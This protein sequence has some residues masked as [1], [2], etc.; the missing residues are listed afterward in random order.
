MKIKTQISHAAINQKIDPNK[1]EFAGNTVDTPTTS[2]AG[3]VPIKTGNSRPAWA[4]KAT[5]HDDLALGTA[6]KKNHA[7][8]IEP[9]QGHLD[10]FLRSAYRHLA[11]RWTNDRSAA[12]DQVGSA[13]YSDMR[14][15]E[16]QAIEGAGY[17]AQQYGLYIAKELNPL[18]DQAGLRIVNENSAV[19]HRSYRSEEFIAQCLNI[20]QALGHSH[21]PDLVRFVNSMSA[22]HRLQEKPGRNDSASTAE[23]SPVADVK[24][25]AHGVVAIEFKTSDDAQ[26]G[27]E[28]LMFL[29]SRPSAHEVVKRAHPVPL[30]ATTP[31]Y[32]LDNAKTLSSLF[33]TE[34]QDSVA[35]L[36]G[37]P[38]GHALQDSARCAA[39][40]LAGLEKALA[41]QAATPAFKHDPLIANVLNTLSNAA[42]ALPT[43]IGDS[44]R[45]FAG[46][47]AMQEELHLLLAA[48]KPYGKDDFKTA[49]CTMLKARAGNTL[50]ELH[51]ADP[52]TYLFSSGMDAMSTGLDIART[53]TGTTRVMTLSTQDKQPDYFEAL[54]LR[55]P[56]IPGDREDVR[57]TPLNPSLPAKESIADN[58]NNW[59]AHKLVQKAKEWLATGTAS[60]DRPA[61]LVLDTT[62]EKRGEGGTSDLAVVL[63]G[64]KD[65]INN[66]LLK[67]LLCKSHQKYSV[68]GSGKIMAGAITIIARDDAKTQ[69]A[70]MQL[71]KAEED[72]D[73]MQNDESQLLT[74]F[75]THAHASELEM[76]GRA[77][78][79]AAFIDEFCLGMR[80]DVMHPF[81]TRREEGLPFVVPT[82]AFRQVG[83]KTKNGIELRTGY[84]LLSPQV[85]K[86]G[87]FAFLPT[88]LLPVMR[89]SDAIMRIAVGQETRE[90]LVEKFYGFGWLNNRN[91]ETIV[92]PADAL[93][94]ANRIASNAAQAVYDT[95]DVSAWAG[96][97]LRVLR[98]RAKPGDAM[99]A[100]VLRECETLFDKIADERTAGND[101]QQK[102][103]MKEEL[104]QKLKTGL[105]RSDAFAGSILSD[106]LKIIGSA[107]APRLPDAVRAETDVNT[108]RAAMKR[109]PDGF[110]GSGDTDLS[111]DDQQVLFA[112][113]MIA[114]LLRLLGIA[115]GPQHVA[116]SDRAELE[117]FYQA[118]LTAGLPGV[119][120]STRSSIVLDWSRLQVQTL[121]CAEDKQAQRTAVDELLRHVHL[122]PY[123]EDKA[124]ILACIPDSTF[125]ALDRPV[126]RKL[127]DTLFAPLDV[128]SRIEFLKKLSETGNPEKA[129][130]CLARFDADLTDSMTGKRKMLHPDRLSGKSRIAADRP[131]PITE[132][133]EVHIREKLRT[134]LQ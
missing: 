24:R 90:E 50:K 14:R 123:R 71:R 65:A 53:L 32:Q 112:P 75:L 48:A 73:W 87:S 31:D 54:S 86:R 35:A 106:Q 121:V 120:P 69:A 96:T 127:I 98:E 29:G 133:E 101:V 130:A 80:P 12:M 43:M 105:A 52:E 78:E 45:F 82:T 128:Y 16:L 23:N 57:M 51:I 4:V 36:T 63:T 26:R 38:E 49:A 122:A 126:Q 70:A 104:R 41:P 108:M 42:N 39:S 113:N 94:Q 64:L 95:V 99:H 61:V 37:L 91:P 55:S 9:H 83:V 66:G 13:L 8:D 134:V 89:P 40:L 67:I 11:H 1:P 68:A 60:A 124:K 132:E 74:H 84:Q 129:S 28:I 92:T 34:G 46:Y 47:A 20:Y 76:I 2:A 97:A 6:N 59:D 27:E 10:D 5:S 18:E 15:A 109:V 102:M 33:H 3:S 19:Y 56:G 30:L 77:A 115:L 114:S 85:A 131:L 116:D 125:K 118:A 100:D 7:Q 25:L 79:N 88:S 110:G 107:F 111:I 58:I 81:W 93:S 17:L 22:A 119:S 21:P 44:P 62:V 103:Q 117:T 72:L